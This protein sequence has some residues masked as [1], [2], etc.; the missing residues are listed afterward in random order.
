MTVTENA[1][2]KSS[3]QFNKRTVV[4]LQR[5]V[6]KESSWDKPSYNIKAWQCLA[7]AKR[8]DF[9]WVRLWSN[10]SPKMLMKTE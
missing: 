2:L 7:S 1:K 10:L 6:G 5:V 3:C 4:G 9:N 8:P